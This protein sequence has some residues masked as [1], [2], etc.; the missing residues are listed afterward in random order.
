MTDQPD[1]TSEPAPATSATS[2]AALLEVA[3]TVAVEAAALAARR[4]SEGVAVAAT[5]SSVVDVVT[6]T[7]REVEEHLRARLAELR[8]GDG[9][10]GEEG[11]EH[12]STTGLTWVVDPIDGTVNFL[13]G[14]PQWAVSVA[15]VEGDPVPGT[16][17]ALAGCVVNPSSGETWTASRGG[18][19]WL[20][21]QRLRPSSPATLAESLVATGFSYEAER[22]VEQV[23]AVGRLIGKVRDIRRQGAASLDL[24][25][26]AT[27]RLDAYVERGLKPWD[28]AA[29]A[30]VAEEAGAV[31]RASDDSAE[32][33]RL[34][35]AAA[36]NIADALWRAVVEA[37]I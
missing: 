11:A 19:A 10:L 32:G 26:V 28:H 29:G 20:G 15:V 23:A 34:T 25:A 1:A 8:P 24:C 21:D 3:R 22:R 9:F 17:R 18:G 12:G 31:V 6:H 5:K 33:G 14:M 37:R 16:W 27:G 30:L 4:R 2:P 7:D 13:Y 35:S 36:P